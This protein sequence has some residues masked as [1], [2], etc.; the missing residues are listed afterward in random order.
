MM[1]PLIKQEKYGFNELHIDVLKGKLK[2]KYS[3]E[4]I[5]KKAE[6]AGMIT[7]V[8]LACINPN[9]SVLRALLA[10]NIDINVMDQQN[11]KP[12]HYAAACSDPGI[13]EMLLD[14]DADINDHTSE[15]E[16]ALHIAAMNG[17]AQL[18][19]L[20]LEKNVALFK[21]LDKKKKNAMTYACEL[22][23]IE[24]IKAFLDFS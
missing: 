3:K 21:L 20:I 11:Y 14:K 9:T 15:H 10:L 23:D 7:P 18:I 4:L 8:H 16:T 12:I 22:G 2:K 5:T 6:G 13:M 1:E 17:N 24:S 19:K